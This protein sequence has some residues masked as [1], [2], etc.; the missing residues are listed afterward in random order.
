MSSTAWYIDNFRRLHGAAPHGEPVGELRRSAIEHLAAKGLP[1]THDEDWKYTDVRALGERSFT[2]VG[3]PSEMAAEAVASLL[4]CDDSLSRLVFVDGHYS[5]ALSD[6][7]GRNGMRAGSLAAQLAAAPEM[8]ARWLGRIA[9]YEA[10]SFAALNTAFIR[11][12]ALVE[13]PDGVIV[14]EPLHIVFVTSA[15]NDSPVIQPRNIIIAGRRSQVTVVETYM[16]LGTDVSFTNAVTEIVAGEDSKI[17][18]IK[19]ADENARTFHVGSLQARQE[20]NSLLRSHC[21]SFGGALSRHN[22]A[23]TLI[24]E[25]GDCTMNGLF[26]ADGTQH[27]DVHTTIDHASA[28]CSSRELFK[29]IMAGRSRGVFNGKVIVR[30]D[31]QKTDARQTNKNLLLSSEATIDTKPQLEIFA[32]DVQC[33]HG[34]TIGRL[35]EQSL[36]YL[37][38][39]GIGAD[40]ARSMLI[41][42]FASEIVATVAGEALREMLDR[43]LTDRMI[44]SGAH[45]ESR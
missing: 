35:D 23:S 30:P 25:G 43:I 6:L 15:R 22:I 33:S 20:R 8:V 4:P 2:T 39:R 17:D 29:G 5:A 40:A 10:D 27:V 36:F 14:E 1:T 12:G 21:F 45:G 32:N 41:R 9:N 38:S 26:L 28:H 24:S 11:D 44:L 19:V 7:H 13:I 34:A 31:A 16:S 37:R 42:A 18:H 3:E